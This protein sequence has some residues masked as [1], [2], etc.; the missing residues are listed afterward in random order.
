MP[1]QSIITLLSITAGLVIIGLLLVKKVSANAIKAIE[2]Y[3][4]KLNTLLFTSKNI[5]E[6]IYTDMILDNVMDISL[7]ATEADAGSILFLEGENLVSK[8][9]KG[10]EAKNLK[11]VSFPRSQGVAGWVISNDS[12]LRI[13]D[14][15]GD[16]RF[17]PDMDMIT[18]SETRSVLCV[19]LR[20]RT[21]IIGAVKLINKRTGPFTAEDEEFIS[22]FAEQAAISIE[23]AQFFEDK[24]NYE[25]HLTNILID[26]SEN[27]PE[28]QGHSR[29]VAKYTNLIANALKMTEPE[30]KRLYHAS[31][32]HDIGFLKIRYDLLSMN[33]FIKHPQVGYEMLQP[34]NFYSEI[35]PI[36][37]HHH[38]RFDGTGY[39]SGLKGKS[40]PLES[41]M[42][43]IA[44]AF[45]SML[46]KLSYKNVGKVVHQSVRPSIAKFQDVIEELKTNA[47]TQFDPELV[48]IFV[49]NISEDYAE[50]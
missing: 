48:E 25:M 15:R 34:I 24:K 26:A 39:P 17:Y 44:E 14:L 35:A 8:I 12:P 30:K 28:K 31:L 2:G 11:K 5:H 10:Q 27:M 20:L 4:D 19:P 3:S 16:S 41:R 21:G 45:D 49:N 37:R 47:G 7:K 38:E 23:R 6:I 22:H 43:F 29:R 40:I 33:E 42:I 32:L 13:D 18:G 9:I 36:V 50:S 1:L 46:S